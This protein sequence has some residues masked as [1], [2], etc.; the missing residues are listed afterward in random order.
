MLGPAIDSRDGGCILD[1]CRSLFSFSAFAATRVN[2]PHAVS[3]SSTA[4]SLEF[5]TFRPTRRDVTDTFS[6]SR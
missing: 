3:P 2:S 4:C 6:A 1:I 5:G